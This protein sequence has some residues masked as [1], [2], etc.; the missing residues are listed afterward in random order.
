MVFQVLRGNSDLSFAGLSLFQNYYGLHLTSVVYGDKVCVVLKIPERLRGWDVLWRIYDRKVYAMFFIA[1][2][3]TNKAFRLIA[4]KNNKKNVLE[5]VIR[6]MSNVTIVRPPSGFRE[7]IILSSTMIFG[8][9]I[10]TV[11]QASMFHFV[12]FNVRHNR[13]KTLLDVFRSEIPLRTNEIGFKDFFVPWD[14]KEIRKMGRKIKEEKNIYKTLN[15]AGVV[16]SENYYNLLNDA[17][18][19]GNDVYVLKERV[20]N[21]RMAYA[22]KKGSSYLEPLTKFTLRIFEAGLYKKWRRMTVSKIARYYDTSETTPAPR[23]LQMSDTEVAFVVL[24]IG[25]QDQYDE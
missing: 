23:G 8:L 25:K 2:F 13:M 10:V 19:L 17:N 14:K 24:F 21:F 22:V 5:M 15:Y 9:I 6:T 11:Y 16:T 12:R 3:I 20:G 18:L 7:R 4:K 1:V